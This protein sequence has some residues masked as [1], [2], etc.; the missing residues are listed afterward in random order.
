MG[1]CEREVTL[2]IYSSPHPLLT[3]HFI[4]DKQVGSSQRMPEKCRI[5]MLNGMK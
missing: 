2:P 4:L 1:G 5:V 3:L